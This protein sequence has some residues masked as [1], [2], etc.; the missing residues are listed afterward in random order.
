MSTTAPPSRAAFASL[1]LVATLM[2]SHHVGA[3]IALDDGVDI[4]TLVFI[5]GLVT[6]IVL[7][8]LVLALRLPWTMTPRQRRVMAAIGPLVCL[9]NVL[10]YVAVARIPVA[11]ALL[12]FNTFPI[13]TALIAWAV[14][15][16]RPP[17]AVLMTTPVILV[18]LALALDV[19]GTVGGLGL[20]AHWA[21]LGTGIAA[22]L[23]TA[24]TFGVVLNL[25]QQ[26]VAAL[27]GRLRT[28]LTMIAVAG[29]SGA[30]ALAGDGLHLPATGQGWLGM[31]FAVLLSGAGF[32][33]MFTVLPRLGVVG[34]SPIMN[35]EP[36]IALVLAWAVLGQ[37]IAPLQ[38]VGALIVVGAVIAL[39]MRRR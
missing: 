7:G 13:W 26:E 8:A 10:I 29:L 21:T 30:Y 5:R 25:T 17:R 28:L 12:T 19:T 4:G 38:V 35:I 33:M 23:G 15:G 14:Y 9:Q 34:S 39:G 36:V 1:L 2:G 3:R 6:A 20:R 37:R 16:R 27:D 24:L 11:L 32:T 22:A 31:A 18:G